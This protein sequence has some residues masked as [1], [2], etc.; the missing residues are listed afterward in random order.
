MFGKVE[1]VRQWTIKDGI[2]QNITKLDK[3]KKAHIM[4]LFCPKCK[5]TMHSRVD[6]PYYLTYQSC[7]GCFAKFT[8]KLKKEGKIRRIL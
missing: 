3:A 4:P 6:K 5:K 1:M 8:D 2:K 7:L